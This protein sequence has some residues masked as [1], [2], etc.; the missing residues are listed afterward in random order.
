MAAAALPAKFLGAATLNFA[1]SNSNL[2]SWTKG[3]FQPLVS[4]SFAVHSGEQIAAWL[5]LLSV[6]QLSFNAPTKAAPMAFGIRPS[7]APQTIVDTFALHF[8]G[9]GETLPQGTYDMEHHALGRFSLFIVPSGGATYS[10]IIS[11]LESATPIRAPKRLN[12]KSLAAA[13][14]ELESR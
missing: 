12:S 11:H 13:P 6:E 3:T 2:G 4:S 1:S 5:T 8:Q 10:A 9:T 14:R 7:K